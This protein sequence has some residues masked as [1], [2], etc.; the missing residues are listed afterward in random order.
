MSS[1][2]K[3]RKTK[4]WPELT[5]YYRIHLNLTSDTTEELRLEGLS[6]RNGA[7]YSVKV[8]AMNRAKMATAEESDGVTIDTTPPVV[9]Q[10][11]SVVVGGGGNGG[12]GF[13]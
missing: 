6:L 4:F 1:L 2:L 12:R 10:V 11:I 9:L 3:G 7:A 13:D 5:D 8:T